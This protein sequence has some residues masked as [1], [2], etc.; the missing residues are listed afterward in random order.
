M[1]VRPRAPWPPL[2]LIAAIIALGLLPARANTTVA[3]TAVSAVTAVAITVSDMPRALRFY[4]EVLD[5]QLVDEREM[6]AGPVADLYGLA[7]AGLRI[8]TLRLGAEH[9]ELVAWHAPRGR[10]MP[11][12]SRSHDG[13][14]Q[15]IAII[16]SDMDAA[17]RRLQRHAVAGISRSPQRLPDSNPAAGGIEAYYFKDPDGH[18]LEI[19]RFPPGKGEARWQ[20]ADRLFLGIDHTA[21]VVRDTDAS[22]GFY[23]DRLGLR[24]AGASENHGIEQERLNDVPGARL[25][26]TTLRAATGPGVELLEYLHPRDGRPARDIRPNDLAHWQTILAGHTDR[27]TLLHD[28]DRH[29]LQL[30]PSQRP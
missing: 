18:P 22:L 9:I 11:Q 21:I 12:D 14:F 13:W 8:A 5:F 30:R 15:H 20:R 2:V 16:V 19:L 28:T 26:I 3:P 27:A 4:R 17:C 6:H 29:A 23:R 7:D 1:P 10:P 25:R 24:V